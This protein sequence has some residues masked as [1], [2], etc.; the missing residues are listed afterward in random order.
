MRFM[1]FL[2]KH[3]IVLPDKFS[4]D[5]AMK[6]FYP[7]VLLLFCFAT[8]PV[9]AQSVFHYWNFNN[10]AFV[11]DF[12]YTTETTLTLTMQFDSAPGRTRGLAG[13]YV[14]EMKR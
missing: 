12:T 1:Q 4:N 13:E 8:L 14:F 5:H 10:S 11:N 6:K 9:Y 3:S 2:R 7:V